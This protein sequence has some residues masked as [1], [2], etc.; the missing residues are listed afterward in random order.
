[1]NI[2]VNNL[3]IF[4]NM[5]YPEKTIKKML[6][7]YFREIAANNWESFEDD[8]YKEAIDSG[9]FMIIEGF[10]QPRDL[11]TEDILI[12][13]D[14]VVENYHMFLIK[15]NRLIEVHQRHGFR[16]C[17]TCAEMG[18]KSPYIDRAEEGD[19]SAASAPF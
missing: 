18:E 19:S 15:K 7:D 5:K 11:P 13:I 2:I 12:F 10:T 4:N 1:M 3:F 8:G 16:W 6:E 9:S 14:G 17:L